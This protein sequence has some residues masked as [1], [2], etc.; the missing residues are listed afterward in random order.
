MKKKHFLI[1]DTLVHRF[2]FH[3]QLRKVFQT[4]EKVLFPCRRRSRKFM[5]RFR[6]GECIYSDFRREDYSR[7]GRVLS[8][9]FPNF[10][11]NI[12]YFS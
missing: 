5:A 3:F 12:P 2:F 9:T 10:F 8:V 11:Y 4:P 6:A 7:P 1:A